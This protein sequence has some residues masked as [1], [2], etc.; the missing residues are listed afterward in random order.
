[1]DRCP[2]T[3]RSPRVRSVTSHIDQ[4]PAP[5]SAGDM[6]RILTR[7]RPATD[8]FDNFV[9]RLRAD[10][11]QSILTATSIAVIVG[12]ALFLSRDLTTFAIGLLIGFT[13][14]VSIRIRFPEVA[15]AIQIV[16]LLLAAGFEERLVSPA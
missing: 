11:W 13:I 9:S 3:F 10:P 2:S 15:L 8:E 7:Q 4:M 5:N 14:V 12:V 6:M 1:H 16:L